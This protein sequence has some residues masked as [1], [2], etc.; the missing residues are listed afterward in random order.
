MIEK[1]VWIR[2]TL[3]L[4]TVVTELREGKQ[5]EKIFIEGSSPGHHAFEGLKM[6]A[7]T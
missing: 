1:T 4:G 6:L 5:T 2:L 3:S 7:D